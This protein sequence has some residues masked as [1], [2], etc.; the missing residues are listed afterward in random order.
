MSRVQHSWRPPAIGRWQSTSSPTDCVVQQ[1]EIAGPLIRHATGLS[2][3]RARL[4]R[5][6]NGNDGYRIRRVRGSCAPNSTRPLYRSMI[7]ARYTKPCASGM[8]VMSAVQ[9]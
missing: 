5:A 7:A 2:P 9:T 4:V 6:D 8:Y 3:A 1:R